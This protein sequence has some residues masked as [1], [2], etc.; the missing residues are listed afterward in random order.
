MPYNEATRM[1]AVSRKNEGHGWV[2]KGHRDVPFVTTVLLTG[3]FQL[4]KGGAC[5]S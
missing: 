5:V 4:N 1:V 2:E 3:E